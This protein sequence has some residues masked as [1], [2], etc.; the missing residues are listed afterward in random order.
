VPINSTD[1]TKK[2]AGALS[3]YIE[4]PG[5][6][7]KVLLQCQTPGTSLSSKPLGAIECFQRVWCEGGLRHLYRGVSAPLLASALETS[8]LFTTYNIA[9]D[10]VRW[11]QQSTPQPTSTPSLDTKLSVVS[12]LTCAAVAGAST[13]F[14]LTPL[15]LLKCHMQV[16]LASRQRPAD[17]ATSI[18]SRPRYIPTIAKIL[19]HRGI[20]GFWRGQLGTMIRE[21]GGTAAWFGAYEAVS[22]ILRN[23]RSIH[24]D[25]TPGFSIWQAVVAGGA[26][27]VAYNVICYPADTIKARMQTVDGGVGPLAAS[28]STVGRAILREHGVRGL[29]RGCGVA[30][31]C[32]APG[33][34][35]IFLIYEA[36]C[37]AFASPAAR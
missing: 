26:A 11:M 13:S 28:F 23:L 10:V 31:C 24:S 32:I 3:K 27:G 33:S 1:A 7:V 35:T 19:H 5:D 8:S 20:S 22:D 9:Q 36:L 29:Y 25:E 30:V 18:R 6:V 16:S 4:Y 37:Y 21:M 15:E 2:I 34:A 17:S 12:R 14:I